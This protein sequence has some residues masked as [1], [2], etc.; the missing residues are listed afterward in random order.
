MRKAITVLVFLLFCTNLLAQASPA[1]FYSI[2]SL[3]GISVR[4]VNSVCDDSNGFIWASSKT[5]ILRLTED[6]YRIYHLPYE[7]PN[8]VMVKL[9]SAP[10]KLCAYTN[11]GQI[12]SYNAIYDRFDLEI[13][14]NK[15]L[16]DQFTGINGLLIDAAGDYWISALA[17][18]YKYHAGKFTLINEHA[19]AN[20]TM[21]WYDSQHLI[22][23]GYSGIWLL[24]TQT[25]N[26]QQ[27]YANKS[28][29]PLLVSSV[30]YDETKNALWVGTLSRGL[31]LF[32]MQTKSMLPVMESVF[33]RQPI[34]AIEK[35]S[36][37]TYLIG[38]DGQGLW[39]MNS[40]ADK[41]LNVYKEN[42]D[43][44]YSIK[45][46]GV[47]DLFL[48]Q[49]KRV[50]I[51]TISGGLSFFDQ[52]SPL[53]TQVVHL[54]NNASSLINNDVN[55]L[56]EDH[57]GKLWFAT[58]N[59]ISCWDKVNDGWKH[60]Y[61]NKEKQAQV[62]LT[63]CEDNQGRIWAGSYSSGVYVIDGNTG[64][65]LAHY[66][67]TEGGSPVVNNFILNIFKDA[68]GDLWF[69]VAAPELISF[70]MKENAFKA[71]PGVPVTCFAQLSDDQLFL[72]CSNGLTL[73]NKKTGTVKMLLPDML[74]RDMQIIGDDVWIGTSGSGLIRYN[75]KNGET[76]KITTESGL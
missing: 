21:T 34:L 54:T 72:G 46:N 24:D 23:A 10:T 37:G 65:E 55:S 1:K 57:A 40:Q 17:G 15:A 42:A 7:T 22:L 67:R 73:L 29:S 30:F 66:S 63:I 8:V 27:V 26:T 6:D 60:F 56:I 71:Y 47:Y 68:Q 11:N 25:L 74:V 76:E 4:E 33:P 35:N 51:G 39:K 58:N 2:N 31:Y 14:L 49:N 32:N 5:S 45:G 19:F 41:I 53:V 28:D 59:G 16:D 9:V 18:L 48:D 61:Y 69:A 64:R 20:Y 43:D 36:D 70:R 50:W 38:I 12:F 62:F 3:F 75:F 52:E 13:N 44:P